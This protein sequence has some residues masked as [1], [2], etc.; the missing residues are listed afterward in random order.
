MGIPGRLDKTTLERHP[1]SPA[2]HLATRHSR[3]DSFDAPGKGMSPFRVA[4]RYLAKLAA[5]LPRKGPKYYGSFKGDDEGRWELGGYLKSHPWTWDAAMS[6]SNENDRKN[7]MVDG[8][9]E[10]HAGFLKAFH[11]IVRQYPE[12]RDFVLKFDGPWIPVSKVL[13]MH[14]HEVHAPPWA[15]MT[16]YHGTSSTAADRILVE[17]LKPRSQTNVAPAYGANVSTGAGRAEA[18]YLTTQLGMAKFA[19]L[20]ASRAHRGEPVILEV[21][22]IDPHFVAADEDSRADDAAGSF[23][24]IGSIAYLAPIPASKIRPYLRMID[25]RWQE[26]DG[27]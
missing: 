11:E 17:G 20:D 15:R 19:A 23:Q 3:S 22:G 1:S 4:K 6:L 16:F 12:L 8:A 2:V 14:P 18:I 25:R 26:A 7:L 27:R 5:E 10:H 9:T 24:R 21:V 13:S